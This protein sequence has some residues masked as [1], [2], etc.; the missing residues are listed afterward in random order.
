MKFLK[1]ILKPFVALFKLLWN[2]IKLPFK[3]VRK[4]HLKRIERQKKKKERYSP[5]SAIT[6]LK[7]IGINPEYVKI[8]FNETDGISWTICQ[9]AK[10]EKK[11]KAT[12]KKED[13][14]LKEKAD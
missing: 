11:A 2:I 4:G 8:S 10:L 12:K 7:Q 9:G 3:L 13:N 6:N 14:E 1:I 5:Y